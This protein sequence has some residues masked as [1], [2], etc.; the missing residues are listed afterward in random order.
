MHTTRGSLIPRQAPVDERRRDREDH[1]SW[2]DDDEVLLSVVAS[3]TRDAVRPL[4]LA[5][6]QAIAQAA[7][8]TVSLDD[9]L[10]ALSRA[11]A[12]EPEARTCGS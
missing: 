3:A 5:W 7:I 12:V 2:Y 1:P 8:G 4:R 6:H 10:V 11:A 9:E